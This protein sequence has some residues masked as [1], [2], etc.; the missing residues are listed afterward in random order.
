MRAFLHLSDH[1]PIVALHFLLGEL[2]MENIIHQDIFSLFYN[3]WTNPQTKVNP[4]VKYLLSVS[5]DNSRTWSVHVRHLSK[6]YGI[7]DP[8]VLL[9][10]PA[11]S[12]NTWKNDI[13]TIITSHQEREFREEAEG[14]SKM[15]WFNVKLLGLNGHPH[16]IMDNVT[17]V[18]EVKKLRPVIKML[19][20]DYYTYEMRAS[21]VGG[22]PHC[23]ICHS[24]DPTQNIS[25]NLQHVLTSCGGTDEPRTRITEE[26]KDLLVSVSPPSMD[27]EDFVQLT[28]NEN[29]WTQFLVDCSSFNL[30]DKHRIGLNDPKLTE[31]FRLNRDMCFSIH[32]LR[33]SK[34]KQLKMDGQA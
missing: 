1:A 17:T 32:K 11:P 34:L 16:P 22:S 7:E 5:N 31:L 29:D 8:L 6:L 25:E 2:T 3:I 12:K 27:M 13:K 24:S 9:N 28:E 18:L 15:L 10:Q 33:L 20:G 4:L 23:R 19:A 21:Q 30:K 14:N 26:I